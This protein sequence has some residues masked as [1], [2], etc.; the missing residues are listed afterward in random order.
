M[1]EAM[2]EKAFRDRLQALC[3]LVDQGR[4]MLG[5]ARHAFNRH[6][7]AELEEMARLREEFTLDLDPFFL[8][9]EA[10]LKKGGEAD[11]LYLTKLQAVLSH[12]ELMI[13]NIGRLADPIRQKSSQGAIFADKAFFHV[14]DLFS[15]QMGLLRALVDIFKT[16]DASLKAYVLN[17][18]QSLKESC[19]QDAAEHS[20]RILDSPGHP[21]S[22][23]LYL[24]LLDLF[25]EIFAQL[26]NIVKSLD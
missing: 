1:N 19:F 22:W 9:V 4:L 14:N 5:A 24:H 11:N 15:Q 2:T 10:G 18:G 6:S 3:P 16:D 12:L 21:E 23:S 20:A 25:R 26:L 8:E 17:E 13:D 7:R